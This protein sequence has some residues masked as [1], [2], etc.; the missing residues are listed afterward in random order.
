MSI[1]NL[2]TPEML[3]LLQAIFI[4]VLVLFLVVSRDFTN[5]IYIWLLAVLFFKYQKMDF[6]GSILP[7]ISID[8][9]LFVFLIGMFSLEILLMMRQQQVGQKQTMYTQLFI[10]ML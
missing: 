3:I 6:A 4:G 8:R 9:I 7:D 2:F 10:T 1:Q 5:G